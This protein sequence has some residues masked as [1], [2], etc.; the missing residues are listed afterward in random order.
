[1][2]IASLLRRTPSSP[3]IAG[4]AALEPSYGAEAKIIREAFFHAREVLVADIALAWDSILTAIGGP[5]GDPLC[6]A[7]LYV[8]LVATGEAYGRQ[9]LNAIADE[10]RMTTL[11]CEDLYEHAAMV[12]RA[13]LPD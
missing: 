9:S 3:V 2:V 5:A 7:E 1:M 4:I 6:V 8:W 12:V 13:A 11:A 10:W